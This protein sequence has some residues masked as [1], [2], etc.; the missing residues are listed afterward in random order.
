MIVLITVN[1][2]LG[3]TQQDE[4]ID[5]SNRTV[6]EIPNVDSMNSVEDDPISES[7]VQ[8]SETALINQTIK[9]EMIIAPCEGRKP[10]AF[11]YM[12]NFVK[13]LLIHIFF[14]QAN[15]VIR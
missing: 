1:S 11:H 8:S 9:D 12:M 3:D 4:C 5:F 2:D 10:L 7:R 6:S 14:L 15:L 13:N